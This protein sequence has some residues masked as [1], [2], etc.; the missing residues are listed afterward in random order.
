M[1]YEEARWANA[2]DYRKQDPN[3]SLEIIQLA[4]RTTYN[5]LKTLSD[6]VFTHSVIHPEYN[7]EYTFEKWLDIY[8]HHIPD[9]IEQIQRVHQS[10]KAKKQ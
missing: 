10:W 6:E 7:D 4:R 5:L 9:H 1:A 2:L 3:D 8:A